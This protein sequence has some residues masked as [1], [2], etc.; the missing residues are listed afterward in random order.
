[1][2]L[3]GTESLTFNHTILATGHSLSNEIGVRET[4][5]RTTENL[6]EILIFLQCSGLGLSEGST[7]A[8]LRAVFYLTSALLWKGKDMFHLGTPQGAQETKQLLSDGAICTDP[9]E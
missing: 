9:G 8:V 1:M 2:S 7:T 5:T 3:Y 4:K 6:A